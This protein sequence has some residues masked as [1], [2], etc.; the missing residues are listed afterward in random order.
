MVMGL[1]IPEQYLSEHPIWI[2]SISYNLI[3]KNKLKIWMDILPKKSTENKCMNKCS[4]PLV[5]R[6]V[7]IKIAM[8][9]HY[10]S[11]KMA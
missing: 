3:F 5:I 11:T 2:I 6:E 4:L 9:Y 7:Q 1:A 8:K 10:I